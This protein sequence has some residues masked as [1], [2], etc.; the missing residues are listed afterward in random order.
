MP[1]TA[2]Y[3][4]QLHDGFTFADAQRVV[5][6]VARL[7]VSHLYLS[8]ILQAASGSMHGYDVIDHAAVAHG[9][10]GMAG[11]EAL[12]GAAREHGLGIIV[13]TVPNHMAFVEP[14]YLNRPLWQVLREGPDAATAAWFD[15]DWAAGNGRL[16]IPVLGQPLADAVA[17][18]EFSLDVHEGEPVIRYHEH[19]YPLAAGT[20]PDPD[21]GPL[22]DA[23]MLDV[24]GRQHYRLADW[25]ARAQV[26]NYRRFFEVDRLIAVRVEEPAVFESTHALL[27]EA[28]HRGLIDGFRVDHPDGLSDP[29][30]YLE[31]LR[32]AL[33]PGTPVWVEKILIGDEPLPADWPTAGTTGYDALRAIS[34]ALVDTSPEAVAAVRSTWEATG[35]EPSL[36]VVERACKR[37]MLDVA[38][39]AETARLARSAARARPDL[40]PQRLVEATYELLAAAEVYRAYVR[41]GHPVPEV[42]RGRLARARQVAGSERP[43]LP[44]ELDALAG[45]ALRESERVADEGAAADFAVRLQQTWGPVMAKGI[46]DTTFYRYH[47]LTALNEV[48][49]DPDLLVTGSP[50]VLHDWARRQQEHWPAGM[51]A[52][53]THDTKRSEDVRARILAVA[54]DPD[55]W[56]AC[57]RVAAEHARVAGVDEPTAHLVWQTLL[58]A[59]PI[60]APRLGDYLTKALREAKDRTGW[61]EPDSAYEQ[62]VLDFAERHREAGPL[63]AVLAATLD[64]HAEAIAALTLGQKTLQ[65]TLPGVPDTYQGSEIIDLSLVDPDNRRPVHYRRRMDLLGRIESAG[66]GPTSP[67]SATTG[68]G[69]TVPAGS[70]ST[71]PA[72][73]GSGS[74]EPVPQPSASE[75]PG[76]RENLSL[77][78]L[79]LVTTL[80]GLRKRCPDL[81]GPRA[82]YTPLAE[83]EPNLVAFARAAEAGHS[84][85][86]VVA[87]TRAPGALSRSGGWSDQRIE[88]PAGPWTDVISG[89]Q[90]PDGSPACRDLLANWPV[91]VLV[92]R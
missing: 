26:L 25:R 23:A 12:V 57:S 42:S 30:A 54:G 37:H 31:R 62:A 8:P 10:G 15:I 85:G 29:L 47:R 60:D 16:G 67:G 49:G 66:V 33:K 82:S 88:L 86:L 38:F 89:A 40:D 70:G 9:L 55:A 6:H 72:A 75:R 41:P 19:V 71:G 73:A 74:P 80:L 81:F 64:D 3:R 13:D 59:M 44:A 87:V 14:E 39:G 32:D 78:K 11:F 5:P 92:R 18:G 50:R 79:H 84:P 69:S 77:R 48:G 51:V 27:L 53:S 56:A 68:A 46:E 17:A 91:A 20:V 61:L 21:G 7:G 1:I 35:G 65:L 22:D 58:G 4:L 43:D 2:T 90:W 63:H 83:D 34:G 36:H 76:T 24:L 28:H 45:L 52:L